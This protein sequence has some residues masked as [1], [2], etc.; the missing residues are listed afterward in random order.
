MA[1]PTSY[2]VGTVAVAANGT[3]VTGTGT[4]WITAGIR[5]GDVFAARGLTVSVA[6]VNSATSLTLA[7]PWAGPA[8]SGA[9]YEVRFVGDSTRVLAASR[10]AIATVE[11]IRGEVYA[12]TYVFSTTAE[13]LANSVP[14][15]QFQVK[16]GDEM[17]RY[18]HSSTHTAV[19]VGRYASAATV[20]AAVQQLQNAATTA[21]ND[22]RAQVAADADRVQF[23]AGNLGAIAEAGGFMVASVQ[24]MNATLPARPAAP[25]VLWQAWADPTVNGANV[26][27]PGDLWLREAT[28]TTPDAPLP[29]D[30][31]VYSLRDQPGLIVRRKAFPSLRPPLT[32]FD[33]SLDGGTAQTFTDVEHR[34]TGLNLGQAYT[35][36]GA[37]RNYLGAGLPSD[38]R[39]VTVEN[40]PF[41]DNFNRAN[42]PLSQSARWVDVRVGGSGRRLQVIGNLCGM[43]NANEFY[44]ARAS[45]YLNPRQYAQCE[46]VRNST[47]AAEPRGV[48]LF[49]RTREFV[50]PAV[51]SILP[52]GYCLNITNTTWDIWAADGTA[53]AVRLANGTH[54]QTW[55]NVAR[56]EA[57]G[58][59]LRAFLGGTLIGSATHAT[60]TVGFSGLG[61]AA[62]AAE[63]AS[64]VAVDN[65]ECGNLV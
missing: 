52:Q 35:V 59:T 63:G 14:G 27:Q 13:G 37:L 46:I 62:A 30:W 8:L 20:T 32:G 49:L 11:T 41:T 19:E 61:L 50:N 10:E 55:P 56:F 3:T 54:S 31:S 2:K 57:D 22:V 38:A 18:H 42:Q 17:V 26:M 4:N 36:F 60:Y 51:T 43:T 16:V 39:M 58:T 44:A 6:S 25:V 7:F 29:A 15:Q 1:L 53:A 9:A 21:A 64:S 65:F 5:D 33:V 48:S 47:N 12:N 34:I 45:V 40:G 24:Q 28:P 23:V